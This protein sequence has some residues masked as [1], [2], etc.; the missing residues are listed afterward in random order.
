M[1]RTFEADR[2]P[3]CVFCRNVS[4]NVRTWKDCLQILLQEPYRVAGLASFYPALRAYHV[5][6][7]Q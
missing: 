3:R 5:G 2:H 1:R 4:D 6:M 7:L